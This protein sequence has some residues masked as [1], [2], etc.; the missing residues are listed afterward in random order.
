LNQTSQD[1]QKPSGILNKALI[2]KHVPQIA[3]AHIAR[4]VAEFFS[5]TAIFVTSE[6]QNRAN[7]RHREGLRHT[8]QHQPEAQQ[9]Q[10]S[11]A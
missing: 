2:Q 3:D 7:L 11:S 4:N 10:F 5:S 8:T 1:R 9:A 6:S